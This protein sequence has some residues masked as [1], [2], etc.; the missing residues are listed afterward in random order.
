V[1]LAIGYGAS[2]RISEAVM[3]KARHINASLGIIRVEQCPARQ[4][5]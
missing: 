4:G 5:R 2:L 1:L 3:L